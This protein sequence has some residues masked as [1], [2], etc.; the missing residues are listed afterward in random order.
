MLNLGLKEGV[1]G[2]VA[3]PRYGERPRFTGLDPNPDAEGVYLH[4][5]TNFF[6]GRQRAAMMKYCGWV[7][8]P[9]KDQRHIPGTAVAADLSKQVPATLPVTH[10]F[11]IERRCRGCGLLFLFYA[12]EQKHWYEE[13]GFGLDS[14]CV[15][16]VPC[17]KKDQEIQRLR[18]RYQMLVTEEV[19]TDA[20]ELELARCHLSLME[21]GIFPPGH[22]EKIR[23]FLNRNGGIPEAAEIRTRLG[24]IETPS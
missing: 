11:D 19:R 22:A 20:E 8:E 21:D 1:T 12:L 7:P 10:Y 24:R 3:H 6:T 9:R 5:N 4:H 16:C 18:R 2:Y 14:D 23:A 13:L 15:R 17:R